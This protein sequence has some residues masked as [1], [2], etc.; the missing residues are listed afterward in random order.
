LVEWFASAAQPILKR[1][2]EQED[3][4]G[5]LGVG[6]SFVSWEYKQSKKEEKKIKERKEVTTKS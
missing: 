4:I 5:H 6:L 2:S 3:Q 1:F